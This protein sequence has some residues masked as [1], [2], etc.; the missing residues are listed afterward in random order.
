MHLTNI[1]HMLFTLWAIEKVPG[2]QGSERGPQV[3]LY[4]RLWLYHT[5]GGGK[6]WPWFGEWGKQHTGKELGLLSL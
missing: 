5:Q 1:K 6:G 2:W 4:A 3:R